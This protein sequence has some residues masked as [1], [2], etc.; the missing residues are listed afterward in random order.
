[1]WFPPAS[2]FLGDTPPP[3]E[4]QDGE[5]EEQAEERQVPVHQAPTF[6]LGKIQLSRR[7]QDPCQEHDRFCQWSQITL[8]L[9]TT[10]QAAHTPSLWFPFFSPRLLLPSSQTLHAS[11]P[12]N[13]RSA[14]SPS[15]VCGLR[16]SS[17]SALQRRLTWKYRLHRRYAVV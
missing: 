4:G 3:P 12:C 10:N 7:G 5:S 17:F 8:L 16:M 9:K 14:S 11:P 6:S 15:A 1:M 2:P 13:P